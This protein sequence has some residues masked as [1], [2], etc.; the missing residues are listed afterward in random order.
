MFFPENR[1]V[2]LLTK[3]VQNSIVSIHE[4]K[5]SDWRL[6]T[7]FFLKITIGISISSLTAK[8]TNEVKI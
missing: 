5:V 6:Q 4:G 8:S 1:N 2:P 3:L 7:R